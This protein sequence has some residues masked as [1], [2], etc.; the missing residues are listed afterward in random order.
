MLSA[1]EL[2]VARYRLIVWR[3]VSKYICSIFNND[4]MINKVWRNNTSMFWTFEL[5]YSII[6]MSEEVCSVFYDTLSHLFVI[7]L[8][9]R[10]HFGVCVL[11]ILITEVFQ[12]QGYW[13]SDNNIYLS[14]I[15][16]RGTWW[17]YFNFLVMFQQ[18]GCNSWF[19]LVGWSH[20]LLFFHINFCYYPPLWV[21]SIL[22]RYNPF[23]LVQN[24]AKQP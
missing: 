12:L 16:L 1:I 11:Q 10:V 19:D 18:T 20:E 3:S 14:K 23:Q 22:S 7:G 4:I 21:Y 6:M 24:K 9:D 15:R 8:G 5:R 2:M 17:S 13:T